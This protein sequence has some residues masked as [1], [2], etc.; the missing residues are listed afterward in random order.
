VW[1][2]ART[3]VGSNGRAAR[4]SPE[5][6]GHR[7]DGFGEQRV[8]ED[9]SASAEFTPVEFSPAEHRT[10]HTADGRQDLRPEPDAGLRPEPEA[11][12]RTEVP[13]APEPL[14]RTETTPGP[15]AETPMPRMDPGD[16]LSPS[17]PIPMPEPP[18]A[19]YRPAP[20]PG[21]YGYRSELERAA[22][23]LPSG[24]PQSTAGTSYFGAAP[25]C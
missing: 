18:A 14:P 25:G 7:S 17:L 9:H 21:P 5:R 23:D 2:A 16:Y 22:T 4:I 15:R 20:P 24:P 13:P 19:G 1:T 6:A 3:V 10:D 8:V 11:N 12:F